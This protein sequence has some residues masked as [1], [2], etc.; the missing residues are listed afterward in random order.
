LL[1]GG[2]SQFKNKN[3]QQESFK[4]YENPLRKSNSLNNLNN[5]ASNSNNMN[6]NFTS[7]DH[8]AVDD[9]PVKTR[10]NLMEQKR[11]EWQQEKN[12]TMPESW[13]F[14]KPGPGAGPYNKTQNDHSSNQEAQ[15]TQKILKKSKSMVEK[16]REFKE[17]N[18]TLAAIA[19]AEN[20]LKQDNLIAE[21]DNQKHFGSNQQN[22][23]YTNRNNRAAAVQ[24]RMTNVNDGILAAPPVYHD[25]S[26]VPVAMK[27]SIAFGEVLY[28]DEIKKTRE[29]ER[30]KWLQ[31]L[32]EQR[33][34]KKIETTR[35]QSFANNIN[36]NNNFES[37]HN[38]NKIASIIK[39]LN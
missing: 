35:Q 18:E 25:Q 37:N 19:E 2:Y 9:E 14:G 11:R 23:N 17:I 1:G 6:R 20:K 34:Q 36:N 10:T 24:S 27:T 3:N 28:E 32:E 26:R 7:Y 22:F 16:L 21:D 33:R 38:F 29:L 13:P 12:D 4:N 15:P 31:E 39:V 30:K 8:M 5:T